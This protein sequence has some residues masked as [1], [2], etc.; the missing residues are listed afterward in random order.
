M[1]AGRCCG[2][3][4]EYALTDWVWLQALDQIQASSTRLYSRLGLVVVWDILFMVN[5]R[6]ARGWIER[7]PCILSLISVH[8]NEA[9]KLYTDSS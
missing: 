4:S 1:S 9:G 2:S 3:D 7:K 8:A 6:S 5:Y